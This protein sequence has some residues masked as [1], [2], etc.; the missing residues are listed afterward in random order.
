MELALL[1]EQ[2]TPAVATPESEGDSKPWLHARLHAVGTCAQMTTTGDS[3][4][5]GD[6]D[7]ERMVAA[8]VELRFK[9][10]RLDQRAVASAF[11]SHG[12]THPPPYRL[13]PAENGCT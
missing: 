8:A 5:R 11:P 9:V 1:L 12:I 4:Q 10:S 6:S 7:L 3:S 13:G 2:M